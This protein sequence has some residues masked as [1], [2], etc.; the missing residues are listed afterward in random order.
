MPEDKSFEEFL[1]EEACTNVV[2]EVGSEEAGE[3]CKELM[4]KLAEGE[5]DPD[6]LDERADDMIGEGAFDAIQETWNE[7]EQEFN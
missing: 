5:V 6:N 4:E 1:V 7:L 2:E 3:D